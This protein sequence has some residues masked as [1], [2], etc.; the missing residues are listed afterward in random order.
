MTAAIRILAALRT[1]PPLTTPEAAIIGRVSRK[2]AWQIL[3]RARAAGLAERLPPRESTGDVAGHCTYVYQPA[4][5]AHGEAPRSKFARL[6]GAAWALRDWSIEDL[7]GV[8]G[9]SPDTARHYV[10]LWRIAG[11]AAPVTPIRRGR[12]TTASPV[13]RFRLTKRTNVAPT[14]SRKSGREVACFTA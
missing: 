7:A 2:W 10:R 5:P 3:E 14:L 9:C 13:V 1:D 4:A 6:W 8:A 11:A 12:R